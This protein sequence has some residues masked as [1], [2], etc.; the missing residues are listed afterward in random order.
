MKK[1]IPFLLIA[2]LP[3]SFPVLAA[4]ADANLPKVSSRAEPAA[5]AGETKERK[6]ILRSG[7]TLDIP[8]DV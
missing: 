6:T 1:F 8:R 2:T 4:D 5:A 7:A 3:L